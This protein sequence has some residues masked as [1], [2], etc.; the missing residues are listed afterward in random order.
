MASSH[1][2]IIH[3]QT[4]RRFFRPRLER[5][6]EAA[7]DAA[8]AM[9]VFYH[10]DGDFTRLVPEL[11]ALGVDVVNPVAPDCMDAAA[12]RRRFGPRLAMWGAVGDAPTWD[13]GTPE[14]IRAEVRHRVATVGVAGLLLSPAYDLDYTPRANVEAFVEA[15][16][17]HA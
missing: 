14:Q 3:P 13:H 5:V 8:P 12:L 4:W 17:D 9:R 16:L 7:R 6:I 2:L 1:G 11:M 10:S 15:V